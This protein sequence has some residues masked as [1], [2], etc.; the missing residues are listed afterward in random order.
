MIVKNS[1]GHKEETYNAVGEVREE[2]HPII[3]DESIHNILHGE[4]QY[5]RK[6]PKQID[7]YSRMCVI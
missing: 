7:N 6:T 4:R 1:F 2:D 5:R 3:T